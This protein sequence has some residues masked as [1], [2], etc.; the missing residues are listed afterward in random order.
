MRTVSVTVVVPGPSSFS[1]EL[2]VP[3]SAVSEAVAAGVSSDPLLSD[4]EA[5]VVPES[6]SA[7]VVSTS[8]VCVL[9]S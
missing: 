8:C 6:S 4:T 7:G 5:V 2:S 3:G 1:S 9:T